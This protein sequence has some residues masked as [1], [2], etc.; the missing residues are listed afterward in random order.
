MS[1]SGGRRLLGEGSEPDETQQFLAALRGNF[2][3]P[4]SQVRQLSRVAAET[5]L[6]K[7][8]LR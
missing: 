4:L 8:L 5:A 2:T 1:C 7:L 6:R 3:K